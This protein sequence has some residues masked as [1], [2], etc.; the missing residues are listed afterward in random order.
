[1]KLNYGVKYAKLLK[2][3]SEKIIDSLCEGKR[4]GEIESNLND[5]FNVNIPFQAINW[6]YHNNKDYIDICIE[7]RKNEKEEEEKKEI[8]LAWVKDQAYSLFKKIGISKSELEKL[9]TEKK[10]KYAIALLNA[11][12][13]L[14]D[15]EK[16]EVN[17]N[18]VDLSSIF[19]DDLN[20]E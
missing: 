10:L 17:F 19:N 11:I 3:Y 14:E 4:V 16:S 6:F 12:G 7:S 20:W 15:K 2:E 13:K 1:M 18:Q 8:G 5:E 9:P